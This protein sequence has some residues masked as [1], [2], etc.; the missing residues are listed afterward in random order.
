MI[1]NAFTKKDTIGTTVSDVM[2][3]RKRYT[4]TAKARERRKSSQYTEVD[5]FSII[6]FFANIYCLL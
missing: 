2:D 6:L 4:A 3:G 1:S 5:F